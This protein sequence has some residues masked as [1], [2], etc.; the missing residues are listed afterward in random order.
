M[1]V[2]HLCRSGS[3]DDQK[4]CTIQSLWLMV[5]RIVANIVTMQPVHLEYNILDMPVGVLSDEELTLSDQCC[6]CSRYWTFVW[7]QSL[8]GHAALCDWAMIAQFVS[9][10][11][12][13]L[14]REVIVTLTIYNWLVR[15][16]NN[17]TVTDCFSRQF[18]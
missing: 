6:A 2:Y 18:I 3:N 7:H 1:I 16:T 17:A 9:V 10:A 14:T 5:F 13:A 4:G 11:Y 8:Q 12:I 15:N